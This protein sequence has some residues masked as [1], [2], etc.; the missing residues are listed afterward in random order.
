[1]TTRWQYVPVFVL[2]RLGSMF[3]AIDKKPCIPYLLG[4]ICKCYT[5]WYNKA[6][7]SVVLKTNL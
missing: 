5:Q 1:M 3:C 2:E 6:L 7:R 4:I